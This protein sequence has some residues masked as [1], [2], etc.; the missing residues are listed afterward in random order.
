MEKATNTPHCEWFRDW[1]DEN[2]QMVYSHRTD[3]EAEDFVDHW[4]LDWNAFV[5]KRALDLGCGNGRFSRAIT[6]RGVKVVGVDLSRDQLTLAAGSPASVQSLI[7]ADMRQL[8]L[9]RGFSL[10]VSLFTSFG[11]FETDREHDLVLRDLADLLLPSGVIVM[12][13]PCRESAMREVRANPITIR[14][15]NGVRV[16]ESRRLT[17]G[18]SRFEKEIILESS[19]Q[20]SKYRESVRLFGAEELL[21]MTRR[22]HLT[23]LEPLW[24]DYSGG[25]MSET[26]SR[27]VYFGRKNG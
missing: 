9:K 19:G 4:R 16:T 23:Q 6:N 22:A 18:D 27:M 2:Y 5:G 21:D 20:V 11:Y 25:E 15:I 1:F 10:I 7:R 12:D 24:G 17:T 8:P 3:A 13:L 14:E 26:K